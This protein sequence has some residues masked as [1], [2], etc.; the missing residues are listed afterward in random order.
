MLAITQKGALMSLALFGI[1]VVACESPRMKPAAA[2]ERYKAA[3][4][5]FTEQNEADERLYRHTWCNAR[6]APSVRM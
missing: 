5:S 1:D 4:D 6:P 3:H 2:V